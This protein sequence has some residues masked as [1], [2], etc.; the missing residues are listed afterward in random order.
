ML[1]YYQSHRW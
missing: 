1:K